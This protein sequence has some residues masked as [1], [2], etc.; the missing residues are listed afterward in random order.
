MRDDAAGPSGLRLPGGLVD[1]VFGLALAGAA[2]GLW[3]VAGG[4]EEADHTG[5]GPAT[6]PR[7]LAALLGV[8]GLLLGVRGALALVGVVA[9]DEVV[10]HRPLSV[11]LGIVLV[12]VFPLLMTTAGYYIAVGVWLPVFL[13]VAG[14]RKPLGILLYTAGFLAFAK[15]AFEIIL[16]VR[17]P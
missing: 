4:F 1:L 13:V 16:G 14:Y 3:A 5:V 8:S 15:V 17:L 9:S 10:T 2:A 12:V 11:L 6:F 7:G